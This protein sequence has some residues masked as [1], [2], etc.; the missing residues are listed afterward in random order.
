MIRPARLAAA[1]TALVLSLSGASAHVVLDAE[2]AT[3]GASLKLALRV[4]HGCSGAAT[5]RLRVRIP[6]VFQSALPQPKPGWELE[7][8]PGAQPAG[9]HAHGHDGHGGAPTEVVWTGR[10]EDGRYDEFVLWVST[11]RT[12]PPGP[13]YLPVVQECGDRVQRWIEVPTE[14]SPADG[15]KSPAP[16]LRLIARPS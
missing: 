10:L 6:A 2:T 11:A 16:V 12:A 14:G 5:T 1:V 15:L 3:A 4:L 7:V 8:V 13:V 9:A